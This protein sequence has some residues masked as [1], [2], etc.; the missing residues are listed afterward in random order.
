M[1]VDVGPASIRNANDAGGQVR[2]VEQRPYDRVLAEGPCCTRGKGKFWS[3]G[4]A[5]F[6][7]LRNRLLALAQTLRLLSKKTPNNETN[8][9]KTCA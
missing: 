5:E 2:L 4:M 3:P 9:N 6:V 8:G 1:P 7:A